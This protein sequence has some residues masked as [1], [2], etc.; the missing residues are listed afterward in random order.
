[1]RMFGPNGNPQAQNLFAVLNHLQK[2]A[3]LRME[4]RAVRR[5]HIRPGATRVGSRAA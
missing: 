3:N 5:R 1:M 2:H 4:V